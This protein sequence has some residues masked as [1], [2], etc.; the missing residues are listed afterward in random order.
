MQGKKVPEKIELKIYNIWNEENLTF[1]QL[2]ARFNLSTNSIG[3]I[4]KRV[5]KRKDNQ[6]HDYS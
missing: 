3:P 2:A 1:K 5:Q 4:I 6:N